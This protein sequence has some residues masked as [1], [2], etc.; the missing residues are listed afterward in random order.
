MRVVR[1]EI[2]KCLD[3]LMRTHS[4]SR[5]KYKSIM[6]KGGESYNYPILLKMEKTRSKSLTPIKFN[7]H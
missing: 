1:E 4:S 3:I 2:G 5:K 6:I 7:A